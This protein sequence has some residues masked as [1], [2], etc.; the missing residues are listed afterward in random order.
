MKEYFIT[1]GRRWS[2]AAVWCVHVLAACSM[3]LH[4]S[5]GRTRTVRLLYVHTSQTRQ[6]EVSLWSPHRLA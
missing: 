6:G 4:R 5:G 2:D 3:L 1:T